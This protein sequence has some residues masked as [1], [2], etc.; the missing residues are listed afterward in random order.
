MTFQDLHLIPPILEALKAEGYS[1]PTPIQAQAIPLI[2]QKRD[3]IGCAQTGTGKTAAFVLPIL[4][5]IYQQKDQQES[6]AQIRALILTPTRELATQIG[7]SLTAYGKYTNLKHAVLYGGVPY[8]IQTDLLESGV[9][10]VVATPGRLLDLI[11]QGIVQLQN[12]KVFVL[13]EADRMLDMGFAPDVKQ[14]LK[15]VP[16]QRQT[17]FFSATM[18]PEIQ[19]LANSML[20]NPAQVEV[21][22]VSSAAVSIKQAVY[23]VKKA[24]KKNLLLYLLKDVDMQRALVFTRTKETADKVARELTEAGVPAEALHA[25]KAQKT[26][27]AALEKFKNS[28]VRVLVA[29]EIAARGLDV[30]ALSHVINYELPFEAETYVHRIGRTG[31]AGASGIAI[32]F[33]D[34]SETALL[35]SIQQLTGK[36][37]P[38]IDNHPYP[39]TAKDFIEAANA[40]NK[41][42]KRRGGKGK[43]G[44]KGRR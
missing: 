42:D 29:T 12:L 33:C 4:Q 15:S 43:R 19:K 6:S 39:L 16:E 25:D 41:N 18:P 8:K 5:L 11:D 37:I 9:D 35:V 27:E 10:I 44:G 3:L 23:Y 21:S 7:E 22:P 38:V 32:S 2:L 24:D 34:A 40:G 30:E 36:A 13:D 14:I 17:L 20:V 28:E 26:R 1:E 31:R